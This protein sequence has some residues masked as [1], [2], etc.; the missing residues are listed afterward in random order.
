MKYI[1]FIAANRPHKN[2]IYLHAQTWYYFIKAS[3]S[4][5]R[6]RIR[7][8]QIYCI[9]CHHPQIYCI[10]CHHPHLSSAPN[11]TYMIC[12]SQKI[13]SSSWLHLYYLKVRKLTSVYYLYNIAALSSLVD[14]EI[15]WEE[16]VAGLYMT[17]T[18]KQL[19]GWYKAVDD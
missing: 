16:P 7:H 13:A 14:L 17:E 4:T 6:N 10:I 11:S 5:C 15:T 19:L 3:S 1:F 9:I 18:L 8:P 2:L 12:F